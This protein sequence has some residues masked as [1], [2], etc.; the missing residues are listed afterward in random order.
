M[1][2]K[3]KSKSL[4]YEFLNSHRLM[5][6]ATADNSGKPEAATV[7]YVMDGEDLLVNTYTYYRKFNNLINNP[8]VACVITHGEE[9]TLQFDAKVSVLDSIDADEAKAK[10][11]AKE[12]G[13]A[14][15]FNDKDTRF[16]RVSPY[17][18]RLRDYTGENMSEIE[19]EV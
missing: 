12:P 8:Q 4:V 13:F 11:I 5:T 19:W 6:L 3:V 15:F 7:E 17:W 18:M 10:M 16:F 2:S 14:D 1:A 9:Y